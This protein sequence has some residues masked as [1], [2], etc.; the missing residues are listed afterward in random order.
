MQENDRNL[1]YEEFFERLSSHVKELSINYAQELRAIGQDLLSE[2]KENTI[3]KEE[4]N[5][6]IEKHVSNFK[7]QMESVISDI[8]EELETTQ[9]QNELLEQTVDKINLSFKE[10]FQALVQKLKSLVKK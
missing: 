2:V 5:D 10:I 3:G 7:D 4:I 9:Q 6:F 8:R 1:N